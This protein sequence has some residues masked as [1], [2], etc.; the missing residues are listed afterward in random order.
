MKAIENMQD[1]ILRSKA[2]S[3]EVKGPSTGGLDDAQGTARADYAQPE[4]HTDPLEHQI[5]SVPV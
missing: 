3:E 2:E 4:H 5:L 1:A